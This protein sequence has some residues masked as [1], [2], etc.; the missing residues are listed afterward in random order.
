MFMDVFGINTATLAAPGLE[1]LKV[2]GTIGCQNLRGQSKGIN[3]TR[4]ILRNL[5]GMFRSFGNAR[6]SKIDWRIYYAQLKANVN[7]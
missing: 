4:E 2:I 3:D 7:R 6:S 1:S 5:D